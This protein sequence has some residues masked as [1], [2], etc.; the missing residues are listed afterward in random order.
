MGYCQPT[1]YNTP[2]MEQHESE[3]RALE[4]PVLHRLPYWGTI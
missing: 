2:R 4:L 1:N 3:H